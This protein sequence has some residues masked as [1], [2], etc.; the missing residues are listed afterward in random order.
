M[1]SHQSMDEQFIEKVEQAIAQNLD[2]ETFTVEQ[3]AR[4]VGLSRS[5]L[6]RKLVRLTGTNASE[7]ISHKR[8]ARA[9]ELL[10]NN[11]ATVA[12]TAY[13]VGFKNP[14][15]FNK[16]FK[17]RYNIS[18]GELRRRAQ[19]RENSIVTTSAPNFVKKH[20]KRMRYAYGSSLT[21]ALLIY[22]I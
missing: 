1:E 2:N 4:N 15:Y 12:E 22:S 18:P 21:L 7:M 16:A 13:R 17:R 10:Q 14:S 9:R 3:L 8:L 19:N 6:H 20:R 11:E 5:M